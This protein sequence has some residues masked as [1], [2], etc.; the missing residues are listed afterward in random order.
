MSDRWRRLGV[1]VLGLL[2]FWVVNRIMVPGLDREL[3]WGFEQMDLT[4]LSI[5]AMSLAPWLTAFVMVELV[6]LVVP[7]LRRLRVVGAD[8]ARVDLAV[9][10]V[11]L[12]I[13]L[14]QSYAMA[15]GLEQMFVGYEP[16]VVSGGM[17]WRLLF[18]VTMTG[19]SAVVGWTAMQMWRR[20][21]GALFVWFVGAE[22]LMELASI[23][24]TLMNMPRVELDDVLPVGITV[25]VVCVATF[26]LLKARGKTGLWLSTAGIVPFTVGLHGLL[27]LSLQVP[28]LWSPQGYVVTGLAIIGATVILGL[29]QT[30]PNNPDEE[31]T[32]DADLAERDRWR[33]VHVG[34]IYSAVLGA[35]WWTST[36]ADTELY[37]NAGT[38]AV[39]FVLGWDIL[40]EWRARADR[41]LVL[42]GAIHRVRDVQLTVD[43][44]RSAGIDAHI[45]GVRL[46]QLTHFLSPWAP[47]DVLVAPDDVERTQAVLTEAFERGTGTARGSVES[48]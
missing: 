28:E 1:T 15:M 32:V 43:A 10:A 22:L 19:A 9:R 44:L 30:I 21:L 6:L 26:W 12:G 23:I 7:G 13:C 17:A 14:V 42:A 4:P 3:L 29:L 16:L 34:V 25:A 20:G 45:R 37:L 39:A 27:W 36:N 18:V 46:R 8:R 40:S 48:R 31:R 41:A 24:P 5:G 33:S 11:W 38:I 2:L 35:S 47:M